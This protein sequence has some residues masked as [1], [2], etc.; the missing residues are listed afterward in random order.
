MTEIDEDNLLTPI[1]E[2]YSI[3]ELNSE[4]RE[5]LEGHFPLIWVEGEISNLAR[6]ASGHLYFS[7]KD[8]SAQVRCAMFKMRNRLLN[9]KPEKG[10]TEATPFYDW[11]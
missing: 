5:L 9:F 2:V 11:T 3:S 10:K 6:P 4:I 7:L 8:Q 1:R